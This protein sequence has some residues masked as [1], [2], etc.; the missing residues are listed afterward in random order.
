[1]RSSAASFAA[2]Q[3]R[4]V[5]YANE[6][7]RPRV[8]IIVRKPDGCCFSGTWD[9]K[10]GV[11][12][13]G[14]GI[15]PGETPEE[16]ALR[17]LKEEAGI[18]ACNAKLLPVTAKKD[19]SP[20]ERKQNAA[21]GRDFKGSKT[22]YVIADYVADLDKSKLDSWKAK[23]KAWRTLDEMDKLMD[24]VDDT[25]P[26][27]KPRQELLALLRDENKQETQ[28]KAAH[29]LRS[30]LLKASEDGTLVPRSP[31]EE[32]Q[33]AVKTTQTKRFRGSVGGVKM[34]VPY[35][36]QQRVRKLVDKPDK[37]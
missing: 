4:V 34:P 23:N 14:G 13:P 10:G 37:A 36:V 31:A 9:D 26:Y 8:D 27:K 6:E 11:A 5:K 21:R 28:Q 22:Q 16:A 19:W 1:M 15:D 17:E 25:D 2:R 3:G 33:P 32:S 35:R 20:E 18:E 7:Y 24:S 29:H 30:I 12:F